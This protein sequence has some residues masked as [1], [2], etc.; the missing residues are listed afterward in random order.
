MSVLKRTG[1]RHVAFGKNPF[2]KLKG[3]KYF[4]R[5]ATWAPVEDEHTAQYLLPP[6]LLTVPNNECSPLVVTVLYWELGILSVYWG[7]TSILLGSLYSQYDR[8]QDIEYIPSIRCI[9]CRKL[10]S[11]DQFSSIDCKICRTGTGRYCFDLPGMMF[12]TPYT[13]V[14][15]QADC[16]A[17]FI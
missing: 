10:L 14:A 7:S 4:R 3:T 12:V 9:K 15:V 11:V 5:I 13:F 1:R 2:G 6:L 8:I 16:P 17:C